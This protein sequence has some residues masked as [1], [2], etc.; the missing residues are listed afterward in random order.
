MVAAI[1]LVSSLVI[2]LAA[3]LSPLFGAPWEPLLIAGGGVDA[4]ECLGPGLE[5]LAAHASVVAHRNPDVLRGE[6]AMAR[7]PAEIQ[8]DI[9]LTRRVIERQLDALRRTRPARVVD[10]VGVGRRRLGVGLALARVPLLRLV[11]VGAR[12]VQAGIAIAG[13]VAAVDRFVSDRR[14]PSAA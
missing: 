4:A 7:S 13:T 12:A 1:A 14:R 10:P 2:L 9:A 11:A 3:A 6:L 5:R 8:A